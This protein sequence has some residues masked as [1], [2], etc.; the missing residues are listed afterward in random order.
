VPQERKIGEDGGVCSVA[1]M[2]P[3]GA[4]TFHCVGTN[5]L[6]LGQISAQ[7]LVTYA[8]GEEFRRRKPYFFAITGCTGKYRKARGEVKI[9]ELSAEEVR[10]TFRVSCKPTAAVRFGVALV[11][12]HPS[13]HRTR[14]RALPS[15][16]APLD[17]PLPATPECDASARTRRGAQTMSRALSARRSPAS[18]WRVAKQEARRPLWETPGL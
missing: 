5:S 1:R 13:S 11:G 8:A 14:T 10:L 17:Y 18:G 15:R 16:P 12:R 2:G 4:T 3:D 7:G 6:P 9:K